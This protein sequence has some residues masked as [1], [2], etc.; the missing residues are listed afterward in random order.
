MKIY[1][2]NLSFREIIS[3]SKKSLETPEN[4]WYAYSYR[5]SVSHLKMRFVRIAPTWSTLGQDRLLHET[6]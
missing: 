6:S 2:G 1:Q 3:F 5:F 4:I